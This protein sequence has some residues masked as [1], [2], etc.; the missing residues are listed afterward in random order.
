L[1]KR[2][3]STREMT[4]GTDVFNEGKQEQKSATA[5]Q[6]RPGLKGHRAQSSRLAVYQH[7]STSRSSGRPKR[8]ADTSA[9]ASPEID[10]HL[11]RDTAK[12]RSTPASARTSARRSSLTMRKTEKSKAPQKIEFA[13][14]ADFS[15]FSDFAWKRENP[16]EQTTAKSKSPEEHQAMDC[17]DFAKQK[18]RGKSSKPKLA[19]EMDFTWKRE[20]VQKSDTYDTLLSPVR[21]KSSRRSSQSRQMYKSPCARRLSNSRELI[22]TPSK[23]RLP[24]SRPEM[25]ATAVAT[26]SHVNK[27]GIGEI[28]KLLQRSKRVHAE[29][30][31]LEEAKRG[32]RLTNIR[33]RRRAKQAPESPDHTIATHWERVPS[34]GLQAIPTI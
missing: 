13:D 3:Q 32:A 27:Q 30:Q 33:A 19:P 23:R 18:K 10:F 25:E 20:T 17:A 24:Q 26:T 5:T 6:K 9:R 31:Q 16:K 14:F 7:K 15:D 11:S 12:A 21:E 28:A 29:N 22:Q 8:K 2:Y 34:M 4:T 1:N